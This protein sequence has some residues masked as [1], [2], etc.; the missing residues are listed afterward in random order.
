MKHIHFWVQS[1][2]DILVQAISHSFYRVSGA[3]PIKHAIPNSWLKW[4]LKQSAVQT[5]NGVPFLR[6][7]GR[8]SCLKNW[9]CLN[10]P[11]C[12]IYNKQSKYSLYRLQGGWLFRPR[13]SCDR[14]M[15]I[16]WGSVG[17]AQVLSTRSITAHIKKPRQF[18]SL[19]TFGPW[20]GVWKGGLALPELITTTLR[21]SS[22]PFFS[23]IYYDTCLLK[24]LETKVKQSLVSPIY[25]WREKTLS[26]PTSSLSISILV[27]IMSERFL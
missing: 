27:C 19:N 17:G 24:I 9:I 1:M 3:M 15:L 25:K 21:H 5:Q 14:G 16:S 2:T 18:C 20:P 7:F 4:M 13:I 23:W 8:M 22:L 10:L 6:I 11:S 26:T 12:I